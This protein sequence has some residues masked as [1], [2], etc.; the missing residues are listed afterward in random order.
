MHSGV[1]EER[2][3]P[4]NVYRWRVTRVD[5]ASHRALAQNPLDHVHEVFRTQ[6]ERRRDLHRV[7]PYRTSFQNVPDDLHYVLHVNQIAPCIDP[8]LELGA[9]EDPLHQEVDQRSGIVR[10]ADNLRQPDDEIGGQASYL[11]FHR[12]LVHDI[13]AGWTW[14]EHAQST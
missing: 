9:A 7:V 11:V 1:G 4:G 3:Q 14:L 10:T 8:K 6:V 5:F 2:R 13:S 12:K